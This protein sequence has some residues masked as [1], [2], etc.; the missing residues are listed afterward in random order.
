MPA[1]T[2][3]RETENSLRWNAPYRAGM[4][5]MRRAKSVSPTPAARYSSTVSAPPG[6]AVV[7]SVNSDD[8]DILKA[9]ERLGAPAATKPRAKATKLSPNH[10]AWYDSKTIDAYSDMNRSLTG[11]D[12]L[13]RANV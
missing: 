5:A 9:S 3:S 13:E 11:Y 8:P 2:V 12:L 7:P 6:A 4:N 10:V 1:R